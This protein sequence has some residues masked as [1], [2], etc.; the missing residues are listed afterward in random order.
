MKVGENI[1][2]VELLEEVVRIKGSTLPEDLA[3][4]YLLA[5]AAVSVASPPVTIQ[6]EFF[7]EIRKFRR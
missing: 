3:S 7:S 5:Q 1:R 6:S 4:Q 2:A